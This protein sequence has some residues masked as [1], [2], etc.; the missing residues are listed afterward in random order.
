MSASNSVVD[1]IIDAIDIADLI[2]DR[3]KLKRSSRGYVGLCPFHDERTPSF[4]VYIDTQSY[5]CFGCHEAGNIF[6][7]LMKTEGIGFREALEI[8]ASRAGIT[9]QERERNSGEKS[10]HEILDM[11]MKFYAENLS[12]VNGSAARA[13]L[14]RRKV[15]AFDITRF[16]LGYSLNSW[17]SLVKYLQKSGVSDKQMLALGLALHG[18]HG[19]YDKFRGRLI[20]PIKDISGRV[21]AFGGRLI[22]GEGAKYINSSESEVYSKRRSLYLIDVARKSIREKKR[23][24]LVEGYM[25][26]VRLHKCGFTEAVASCGTS[27]TPEQAE[28]L[29]R[30]ADRC[31]ICYDSDTAGQTATI[32]GMYILAENG[33]DVYVVDIPEGKDP[34]EFLSVNAPDKFEEAIQHAKPLVMKHMEILA[35]AIKA[36][37]TRKSAMRELFTSLS[38]L[39]IAEILRYKIR[40]SELTGVPPSKIEEWFTSKRK[41]PLPAASTVDEAPR[42][43]EEPCEAGLC[44]LLFRYAECRA[45]IKPEDTVKML[46]NPMARDIALSFLTENPD[47]LISLWTSLGETDK[48]ALLARGDEFCAQMI[49]MTLAEKWLNVY[50]VLAEKRMTRRVMELAAKMQNSQA[51]P[52]ELLE[53]RELKCKIQQAKKSVN[54]I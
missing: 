53:L 23:S 11:A 5:Y 8:L 54:A 7:F 47:N 9:L 28:M 12:G 44:S 45:K 16:S 6:T 13:Y 42:N 41:R 14:E 17:D 43:I 48:F 30:F 36:P 10:Y 33:L 46:R 19:I 21:I 24:I 32:R 50:Y 40:L 39:D 25:D 22:D 4:H 35:P 26:A 20:F 34:D 3:V 31:Y 18:N 37:E 51:T 27:L 1:Q 38:R 29:S 52:Q 15:D 49:G 2:S